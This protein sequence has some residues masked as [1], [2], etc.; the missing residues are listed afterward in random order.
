[1]PAVVM[2]NL[3]THHFLKS[4]SFFHLQLKRSGKDLEGS[5]A[6]N[7]SRQIKVKKI[8]T[9]DLTIVGTDTDLERVK[10]LII[11]SNN[12]SLFVIDESFNIH[13]I[14]TLNELRHGLDQDIAADELNAEMICR[15]QSFHLSPNDTLEQA[16]YLFKQTGEEYIAILDD[17]DQTKI[18]GVLSQRDLLRSYNKVLI[19]AEDL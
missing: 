13:G 8:M 18:I 17:K 19:E 4:S 2:A 7:L 10:N 15:K 6:Q 16:I 9:N 12:N 5:R 14:I 11:N 3:I 1:M